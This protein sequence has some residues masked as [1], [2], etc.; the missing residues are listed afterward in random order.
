MNRTAVIHLTHLSLSSQFLVLMLS[1]LNRRSARTARSQSIPNLASFAPTIYQHKLCWSHNCS[2]QG[3]YDLSSLSQSFVAGHTKGRTPWKQPHWYL[4]VCFTTV[5]RL[6]LD[7]HSFVIMEHV[8]ASCAVVIGKSHC[9][10]GCR[11]A[12]KF[13]IPIP[14]NYA[15][16]PQCL[17]TRGMQSTDAYVPV[18]RYIEHT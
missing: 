9:L 2:G 14:K 1:Y 5:R 7:T 13:I 8:K 11:A 16:M 15:A 18:S 4:L 6:V 12:I 10:L 3:T 17:F